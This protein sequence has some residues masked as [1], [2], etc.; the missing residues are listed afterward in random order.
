[1]NHHDIGRGREGIQSALSRVRAAVTV[2]GVDTDRLYPLS[3]QLEIAEYLGDDTRVQV[4]ESVSGHDGFLSELDQVGAIV[5]RALD[6]RRVRSIGSS[7]GA[8]RSRS[9]S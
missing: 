3:Q 7:L 1:M 5:H 6:D 8:R 4:I 9:H 2:A